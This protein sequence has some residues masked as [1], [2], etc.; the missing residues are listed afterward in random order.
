MRPPFKADYAYLVRS[1][2]TDIQPS[3]NNSVMITA[4]ALPNS[5]H[6]CATRGTN[7]L[8]C[9]LTI[10]HGYGPSVPHFSLGSALNTICLH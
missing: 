7:T 8:S 1:F 5:E 6:L 9:R 4:L 3:Q 2:R 10:L